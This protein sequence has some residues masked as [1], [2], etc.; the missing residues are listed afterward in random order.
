MV[1]PY[2]RGSCRLPVKLNA[3]FYGY[4]LCGQLHRSSRV[5][6]FVSLKTPQRPSVPA[7]RFPV[8]MCPITSV[9][10]MLCF[11]SL[12]LRENIAEA[13][14]SIVD[15]YIPPSSTVLG[16]VVRR[17]L[18]V[19]NIALSGL[20]FHYCLIIASYQCLH[21]RYYRACF[22]SSSSCCLYHSCPYCTFTATQRLPLYSYLVECLQISLPKLVYRADYTIMALGYSRMVSRCHLFINY[23]ISMMLPCPLGYHR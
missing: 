8:V 15:I 1:T 20:F 6:W 3:P 16:A 11:L 17:L 14:D 19:L 5:A 12:L 21:N 2:G 7:T 4:R 23:N 22:Y 18:S 13:S 9:L 10:I